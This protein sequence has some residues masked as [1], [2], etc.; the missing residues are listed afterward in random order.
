MLTS[1]NHSMEIL[2]VGVNSGGRVGSCGRVR[3]GF[4]GI[5]RVTL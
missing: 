4:S 3:S 5:W 2:A 1:A